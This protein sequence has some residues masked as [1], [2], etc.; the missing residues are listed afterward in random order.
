MKTAVEQLGVAFR[1]WQRDWDNFREK[2]KPISFDEFIK[3]FLEIEKQQIIEAY[4]KG[5]DYIFPGKQEVEQYYNEAFKT[6]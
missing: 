6:K 5:S 2:D 4:L 3:P 1:Q